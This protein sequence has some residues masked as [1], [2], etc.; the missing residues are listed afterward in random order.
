MASRLLLQSLE[1]IPGEQRQPR[2]PARR[3]W[4]FSVLSNGPWLQARQIPPVAALILCSAAVLRNVHTAR[5]RPAGH[6]YRTG[7]LSGA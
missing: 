3:G 6:H 2:R 4:H 1:S 5:R 7:Y